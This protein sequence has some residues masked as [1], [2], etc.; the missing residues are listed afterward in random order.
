MLDDLPFAHFASVRLTFSKA[1]KA[2]CA[3]SQ[4]ARG[5]AF[6]DRAALLPVFADASL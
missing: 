3:L 1:L 6:Q 2:F 5:V 4:P